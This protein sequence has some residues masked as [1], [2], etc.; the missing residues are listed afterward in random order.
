MMI[1]QGDRDGECALRGYG[2]EDVAVRCF[3]AQGY[4]TKPPANKQESIYGH[5]DFWALDKH[6]N[7]RSV[8]AK[9]RKKLSR[10]DEQ[11]Q[12]EWTFVELKNNYGNPGWIAKGAD[13]MCFELEDSVLVIK[14][15]RL[16]EWVMERV[17]MSRRVSYSKD[18][19]YCLYSR[20]GRS[21]LLTLIKLSDVMEAEGLVHKVWP[22]TF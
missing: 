18:A 20:E 12:Y 17:D 8:D 21:D 3:E 19:K 13:F 7:W 5:V 14:R 10:H 1:H 11:A 9:A 16:H 4:R 15:S 6:G 22:K 2:F